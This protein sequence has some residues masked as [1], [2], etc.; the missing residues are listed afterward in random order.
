MVVNHA[1]SQVIHARNHH[2]CNS[3]L[4]LCEREL[5]YVPAYKYLRCWIHEFSDNGKIVGAL[6]SAAGQSFG[7]IVNIFK[8]FG[9]MGYE[10]YTM[11]FDSYV[12]PVASYVVHCNL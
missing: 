5:I 2:L 10:M 9:D 7:R 4:V 3:D 8:K 6:A 11:L 1:K 12:L